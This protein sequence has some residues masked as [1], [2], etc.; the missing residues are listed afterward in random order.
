MKTH[1]FAN[2]LGT[3]FAVCC[4]V[5]SLDFIEGDGTIWLPMYTL[6]VIILTN[7]VNRIYYE[8]NGSK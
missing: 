7:K 3:I 1:A 4:I 8:E 2:L 6:G 5:F